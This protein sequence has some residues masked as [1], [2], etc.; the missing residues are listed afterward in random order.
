[1][2]KRCCRN[3]SNLYGGVFNIILDST[4]T[5][6]CFKDIITIAKLSLFYARSTWL[7]ILPKF[8]IVIP[9]HAAR[10]IS[11]RH[12]EFTF[13]IQKYANY[14]RNVKIHRLHPDDVQLLCQIIRLRKLQICCTKD[15]DLSN[16][17]RFIIDL[18]LIGSSYKKGFQVRN[19]LTNL[20]IQKNY[21]PDEFMQTIP[22]NI[23]EFDLFALQNFDLIPQ[24]PELLHMTLRRAGI[25]HL[26]NI[27]NKCPKLQSLRLLDCDHLINCDGLKMMLSL[28]TLEIISSSLKDFSVLETLSNLQNLK[29]NQSLHFGSIKIF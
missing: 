26:E 29:I 28:E 13:W 14:I 19:C 6:L 10:Y 27:Q 5:F 17:P 4:G 22:K 9:W 1:M 15:V 12:V 3:E 23:I 18:K 16:L 8:D 24:L 2:S 11:R 25:L 7:Y 20:C 21:F